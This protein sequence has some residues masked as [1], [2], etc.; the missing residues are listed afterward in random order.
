ME[1]PNAWGR[2]LASG[3]R[4]ELGGATVRVDLTQ[5]LLA[6]DNDVDI[7]RTQDALRETQIINE[8]HVVRDGEEV[9]SFLHRQGC[10]ANAPQPDF[11]ILNLDLPRKDGRE[12]LSE[13]RSDP[14][15]RSIPVAVLT[16]SDEEADVVKSTDLDANCYLTKP[17]DLEQLLKVVR[18][19]EGLWLG[20]VRLPL[21]VVG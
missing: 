1:V 20:L 10:Y 11:V 8:L 3:S 4:F 16:A 21:P 18:A 13:M 12:V 2:I 14:L 15:L 5:I 9:L 7:Q 19:M 6:E 17:I